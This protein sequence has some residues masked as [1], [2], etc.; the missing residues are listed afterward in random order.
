MI[1]QGGV[2]EA[3]ADGYVMSGAVAA[4]F[5]VRVGH[6]LWID[7]TYHGVELIGRAV[8]HYVH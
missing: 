5:Y 6:A 3:L 1:A 2:A 7:S 8:V 4:I